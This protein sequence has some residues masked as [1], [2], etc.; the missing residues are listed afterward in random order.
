MVFRLQ[1]AQITLKAEPTDFDMHTNFPNKPRYLGQEEMQVCRSLVEPLYTVTHIADEPVAANGNCLIMV[2]H[3]IKTC[4]QGKSKIKEQTQDSL[5]GQVCY[6]VESMS[7]FKYKS[8]V[9]SQFASGG[10]RK[11]GGPGEGGSVNF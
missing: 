1:M 3:A 4:E 5:A 10:S 9:Q 6:R 11:Y 2:R 7:Q 8:R